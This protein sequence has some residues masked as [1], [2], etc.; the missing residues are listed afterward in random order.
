[1][2]LG[3][4]RIQLLQQKTEKVM[5]VVRNWQ[6]IFFSKKSF[7][8]VSIETKQCSFFNPA[9]KSLPNDRI[10]SCQSPQKNWKLEYFYKKIFSSKGSYGH[11]EY[12]ID[13]PIEKNWQKTKIFSLSVRKRTKK[14]NTFFRKIYL[15][16]CSCKHVES[17]SG[18]PASIFLTKG[19][20]IFAQCQEMIKN[21][22]RFSDI[23]NGKSS[24]E[25]R[26]GLAQCANKTSQNHPM[27]TSKAVFTTLPKVFVKSLKVFCSFLK[28]MK[29]P[30]IFS[31]NLIFF[32]AFLSTH[33]FQF[34]QSCSQYSDKMLKKFA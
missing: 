34:R 11:V 6:R 26:K 28:K 24:T 27:P 14:F 17:S 20:K 2:F 12:T 8:N 31:K 13:N 4:R 23:P 3:T 15:S 21:L 7:Q 1:M 9:E 10:F 22:D 32:K 33:R 25:C 19:R 16:N 29:T 5:I 18:S 30:T